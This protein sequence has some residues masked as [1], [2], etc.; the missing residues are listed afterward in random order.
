MALNELT[1]EQFDLE[2]MKGIN[3]IRSGRVMSAEEVEAEIRE[4]Y[5]M[6]Q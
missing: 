1:K 2:M 5:S 3:D 4:L 6:E